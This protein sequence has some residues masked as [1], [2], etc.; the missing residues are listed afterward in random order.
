MRPDDFFLLGKIVRTHGVKGHLVIL[1]DADHPAHYKNVKAFF[2][3]INSELREFPVI[4]ISITG[5]V[6]RVLLAGVNDMTLA[7]QYLKNNV[8]LPMSELP[9]LKTNQFYL[10]ELVGATVVDYEN[11]N[12]GTIEK[13]YDAPSQAIASVNNNGREILLPLNNHFIQKFDR[14]KKTLF[15]NLPEGLV[16]IYL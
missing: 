5:N 11:G 1:M 7:E 2:L 9:P 8:Y 4:E 10:H 13:F 14:Q 3:N 6:A 15:V 16:D 12:I